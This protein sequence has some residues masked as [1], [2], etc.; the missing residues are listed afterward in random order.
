MLRS[1]RSAEWGREGATSFKAV[2]C[3]GGG[4]GREGERE[5]RP[6]RADRAQPTP[7]HPQRHLQTD[8]LVFC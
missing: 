2:V 8:L 6:K 3:V 1:G 7:T 5:R 4:G